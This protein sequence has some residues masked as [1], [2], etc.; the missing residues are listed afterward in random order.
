[1]VAGNRRRDL[2]RLAEKERAQVPLDRQGIQV[3][4]IFDGLAYC[5]GSPRVIFDLLKEF[6][7]LGT[8][9]RI[10]CLRFIQRTR[11]INRPS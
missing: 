2:K 9:D 8:K 5:T 10:S 3:V 6:S 11:G 1:M 4:A 7:I